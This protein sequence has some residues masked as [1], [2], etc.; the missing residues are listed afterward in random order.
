LPYDYAALEPYLAA[1]ALA[2]HH[3][4]H[5]AAY[6][7]GLNAT[8]ERLTE[9]RRL[10]RFTEVNQLEQS[11]AFYLSGHLLHSLFWRN[12]SPAGGGSPDG[13][14]GAAIDAYF[15]S[16]AAFKAQ[17]TAAAASLQGVGWGA[18]SWEPVGRRLIVEQVL[19]HQSN[20]GAGTV[21]LLV[22]DVWEHAYYLQYRRRED[23]L[24]SFWMLVD[25]GDV[26]E[27]FVEAQANATV[28]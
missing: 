6:V 19:D 24:E 13:E 16:F 26:G 17:L 8:L 5:H 21:P 9:A 20:V 11:Q 25:W 3:E 15:D 27:R 4:R 22:V 7:D 2:L 28:A 14:L 23:W 1:E 10:E 18:L 12:L